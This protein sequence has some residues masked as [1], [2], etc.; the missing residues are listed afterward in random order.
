MD[1]LAFIFGGLCAVLLVILL[2]VQLRLNRQ[3]KTGKKAPSRT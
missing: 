2:V 3:K 1:H